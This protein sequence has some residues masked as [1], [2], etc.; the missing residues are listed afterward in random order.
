[1]AVTGVRICQRRQNDRL[2]GVEFRAAAP[3]ASGLSSAAGAR[4]ERTNCNE[5]QRWVDCPSG[6]VATGLVVHR[7]GGQIEGLGLQCRALTLAARAP[8]RTIRPLGTTSPRLAYG[9]GSAT[10]S[11]SGTSATIQA[12]VAPGD[13]MTLHSL[14]FGERSDKPCFIGTTFRGPDGALAS[15][16]R[17]DRCG[18][19]A[20]SIRRVEIPDGG[21]QYYVASAVKVC[22]RNSNDRLKG[23]RLEGSRVDASGATHDPAINDQEQRT[24]CND[25]RP[26]AFCPQTM[27]AV[28]VEVHYLNEI[29]AQI[30]GLSLR[31]RAATYGR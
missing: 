31:C 5:W 18:G 15:G 30:T 16:P 21:S 29:P 23:I 2:K 28:G 26:T 22:H 11:I 9:T 4:F 17:F 19:S 25:W 13:G 1:L 20:G 3:T 10:S 7:D 14:A 8:T 27:V 24:N 6:Q 12:L